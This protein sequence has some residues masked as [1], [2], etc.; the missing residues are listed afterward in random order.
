MLRHQAAVYGQQL[1]KGQAWMEIP[2]R[3]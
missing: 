1:P 2:L 3:Q